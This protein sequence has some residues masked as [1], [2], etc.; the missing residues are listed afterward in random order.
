MKFQILAVC[1]ALA[2]V[3]VMA[4]T[5]PSP[6]VDCKYYP[7]QYTCDQAIGCKWDDN[8]CESWVDDV[9]EGIATFVIII[10]VICVLIVIGIIAC[11]VCCCCMGANAMRNKETVVVHQQG[12]AAPQYQN[13]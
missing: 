5:T 4:Q 11:I 13:L 2:V 6:T 3:Q 12:G 10:I 9:A 1:L 8:K 7:T